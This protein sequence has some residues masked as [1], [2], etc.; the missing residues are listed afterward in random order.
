MVG[1]V[2]QWKECL[3]FTR[4]EMNLH[5]MKSEKRIANKNHHSVP[6]GLRKATAFLKDEYLNDIQCT[7]DQ[8]C[9]YFRAKCSH[10]FRKNDPPHDIKI[11][12]T[13]LSGEVGC[14][15]HSCVAGNVGYCNHA[16]ALM[17]KLC[18]FSLY[19]CKT[20]NDLCQEDNQA[21]MY[22]ITSPL[23]LSRSMKV[24]Y[25]KICRNAASYCFPA[26]TKYILLLGC[27]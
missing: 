5:I 26:G 24:V 14:A 6:T 8:S 13:I 18:K 25:N 27:T 7:S 3:C 22:I 19:S 9:F 23:K 10:S 16:V 20:T 1:R 2:Y 15:T 17:F 4:A 21:C 11:A 12:L